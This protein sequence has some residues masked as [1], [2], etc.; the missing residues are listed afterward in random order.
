MLTKEKRK[1]LKWKKDKNNNNG[2][3]HKID[4]I[5]LNKPLYEWRKKTTKTCVFLNEHPMPYEISLSFIKNL[6]TLPRFNDHIF[7]N[8]V[9]TFEL[10]I[11]KISYESNIFVVEIKKMIKKK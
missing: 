2:I 6:H 7:K 4:Y 11:G 10:Q 3:N 8:Y 1:N 9:I 5:D